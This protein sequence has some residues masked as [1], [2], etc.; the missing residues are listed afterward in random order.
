VHS[1]LNVPVLNVL[2]WS[3]DETNPTGTEY[4]IM[5]HASG[6]RLHQK[7]PEMNTHQHKLCVKSFAADQAQLVGQSEAAQSELTILS[8]EVNM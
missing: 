8:V 3:N 6:V 4:I 2:D 5:E 1:N 7:W